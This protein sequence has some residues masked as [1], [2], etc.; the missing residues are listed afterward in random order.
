MII[1]T[2]CISKQ[3][4]YKCI[5][6]EVTVNSFIRCSKAYRLKIEILN[7]HP[8]PSPHPP[9]PKKKKIADTEIC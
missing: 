5:Q 1:K 3:G 4:I 7:H 8:I 9:P 6:L 2:V